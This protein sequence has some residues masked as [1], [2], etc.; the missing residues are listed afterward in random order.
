VKL[1][2][3]LGLAA[4]VAR[5][6]SVAELR[7]QLM[8]GDD[9]QAIDVVDKLGKSSDP[10]ALDVLLDGLALGAQPKLQSWMLQQLANKKDP[11]AID[12]LKHFARN[13]NPE[14]R[15]KALAALA[16]IPDPRAVRPLVDALADSV[17]EVRGTAARALAERREKSA[18]QRLVALFRHRDAAAGPALAAIGT[19]DLAHRIAE[20]LGEVPD[21]LWC[22]TL[23]EMLKRPDFGPEPIRVELVHAL[24]KVPGIDSTSVLVE[25][26]AATEKDKQRP[27]RME[28]QKIVDQRSSQ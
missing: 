28:A 7:G 19:P 27:S 3:M 8:A 17:E 20:M 14:L 16:A 10:K 4:G 9:D 21:S 1:L 6:Q 26:I 2:L 5:A 25:Y 12:V 13:R 22:T 15:K 18:E 23:G 24:S 11:R